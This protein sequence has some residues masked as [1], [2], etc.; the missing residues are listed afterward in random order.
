MEDLPSIHFFSF[1]MV[2][3]GKVD[4]ELVMIMYC[5]KDNSSEEIRSCTSLFSV[6]TPSRTD[7]AGLK[8]LGIDALLD[9]ATL[10]IIKGKPILVGGGTD[11]A[12]MNNY[13]SKMEC[14]APCRG[15]YLG[16]FGRGAMPI[17]LCYN[18]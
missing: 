15:Y 17:T 6:Q 2:D 14:G 5:M 11:V 18:R 8:K 12:S 16:C 7:A 10:L 9:Q 4:D 3:A 1:L 13:Q